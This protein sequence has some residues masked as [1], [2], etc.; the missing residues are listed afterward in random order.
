MI[1]PFQLGTTEGPSQLGRRNQKMRMKKTGLQMNLILHKLKVV[2]TAKIQRMDKL[3]IRKR[4]GKVKLI[5]MT[6]I[7]IATV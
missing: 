2:S 4:V 6:Q 1:F 3:T 5:L 7:W